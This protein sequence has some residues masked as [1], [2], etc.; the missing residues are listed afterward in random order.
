MTDAPV[1]D[2]ELRLTMLTAYDGADICG[3]AGS[4]IPK[5]LTAVTAAHG[6]S[7]LRVGIPSCAAP[8][9]YS[10]HVLVAGLQETPLPVCPS[11]EP[12]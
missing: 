5:R 9:D 1:T 8:G 11:V 3:S 6:R 10:G 4:F 7:W 2:L 12:S